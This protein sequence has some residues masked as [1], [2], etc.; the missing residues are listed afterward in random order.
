MGL[1]TNSDGDLDGW[2]LGTVMDEL[3]ELEAIDAP[4]V[5]LARVIPLPPKSL[6]SCWPM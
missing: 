2:R 3:A 1:L 4:G 5:D 6:T